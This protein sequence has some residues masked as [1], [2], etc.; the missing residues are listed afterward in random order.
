MGKKNR[1]KLVLLD[2]ETYRLAGEI[3]NFSE[4]VR[5]QLRSARNKRTALWK[6]CHVC[7]SSMQTSQ[8]YCVNKKCTGY[9]METLEV[10][11]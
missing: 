8:S 9:L 6:Y 4:W 5:N 11:E 1:T 2:D 3:S 7:D 10:L